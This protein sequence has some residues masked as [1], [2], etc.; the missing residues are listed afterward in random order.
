MT[1]SLLELILNKYVLGS[2]GAL[3][4]LLVAYIKGRTAAKQAAEDEKI[5]QEHA[6]SVKLRAA[7]AKNAF[8]EKKGEVS[9]ETIDSADSIDKLIGMFDEVQSGKNPS[10]NADKKPEWNDS[11]S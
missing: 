6:L 8:I 4:A 3:V 2:L 10:G 11:T 5:R 9:N 7:E 1:V